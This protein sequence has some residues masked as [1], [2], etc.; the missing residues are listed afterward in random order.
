[1]KGNKNMKTFWKMA[2]AILIFAV[3]FIPLGFVAY[4]IGTGYA[5]F[6]LDLMDKIFP[7]TDE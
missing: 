7:D 6:Y 3:G 4:L 5:E 1:M 2:I